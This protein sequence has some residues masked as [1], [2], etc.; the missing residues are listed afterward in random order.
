LT[1]LQP[2]RH[3]RIPVIVAGEAWIRNKGITMDASTKEEY[4]KIL[5]SLP[6]SHRLDSHTIKRAIKYAYHFF[7]R[8]MIPLKFI[9]SNNGW[10]PYILDIKSLKELERGANKGLDVICEGIETQSPFIYRSEQKGYF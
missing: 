1:A 5:S 10:P 8:R 2:P 4:F 6:L 7:L 9:K 3:F